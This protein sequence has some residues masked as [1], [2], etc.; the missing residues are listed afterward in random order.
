METPTPTRNLP[1]RLREMDPKGARPSIPETMT[2]TTSSLYSILNGLIET[3]KDGQAGFLSASEH[4]SEP[5]I[6]TQLAEFS[7]QRSKFA[8]ELQ[9]TALHLGDKDPEDSGS[10]AAAIHR[11]WINLKGVLAHRDTYQILAECET[12]EDSAVREYEKA[13]KQNLP[14]DVK[15]IVHE[16]FTKVQAAHHQVKALRDAAKKS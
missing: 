4:V 11:G 2:A 15:A 6:R 16:Q 13:L 12:G 5:H 9:S 10:T 14:N 1:P 3:C 7:L 8:G